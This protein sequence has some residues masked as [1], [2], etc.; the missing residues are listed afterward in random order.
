[1]LNFVIFVVSHIIK[2]MLI[3]PS[4]NQIGV[5]IFFD[6]CT[7]KSKG[8]TEESRGKPLNVFLFNVVVYV[9][10][11]ATLA[12]YIILFYE[13]I[14]KS[15]LVALAVLLVSWAGWL[16]GWIVK[17]IPEEKVEST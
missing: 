14:I 15:V 13:N 2:K 17:V 8:I 6:R 4:K 16:F 12:L 1:M 3:K 5:V 9:V 10:I 7:H 11:S